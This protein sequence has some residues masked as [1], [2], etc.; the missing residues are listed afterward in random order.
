MAESGSYDRMKQFRFLL[1]T[2][3]IRVGVSMPGAQ[4]YTSRSTGT[5]I[6][7]NRRTL[8]AILKL[9]SGHYLPGRYEEHGKFSLQISVCNAK[10]YH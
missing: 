8:I 3:K 7:T 1:Y 9:V 2:Y 5:R 4:F 10:T 6:E